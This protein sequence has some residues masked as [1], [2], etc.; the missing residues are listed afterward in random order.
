VVGML[1]WGEADFPWAGP[2][3]LV[4]GI[5]ALV[6]LNGLFVAVEFALVAVRK[7]RVEEMVRL[8]F[9]R[10]KTLEGAINHLDRSI[11]A[12][13][14]GTTLASI[15]LG[16][17]GEP[18]LARILQ[19]AFH[20]LPQSW[21]LAAA[22]TVATIIAF[23]LITF[24]HVVFGELVP[25]SLALQAPDRAALWLVFPLVIFTRL[26]RPLTAVMS[27]TANGILRL[28]GYQPVRGEE[29][30]HSVEE[31]A[32]LIE[33]TE[34]AGILDADQAEFVQNVF[35]MSNKKVREC[36]VPADK[37]ATLELNT[38]PDK[39]LEAARSGAHTRM[40]V[41]EGKLDNI[42]GIV[43]TKDLFYLFSLRGV[44][45]LHD[46]LYPALFLKPDNTVAEALR[47]FRKAH[48][49]MA[50][51]RDNQGK[52]LGL[53]TLEDVLEEIVGDIEDEHDRP[54]PKLSLRK[55]RILSA[56]AL[57]PALPRPGRK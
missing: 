27:S 49:P 22:H 50:L 4:L 35:R 34:E 37:M 9:K 48:R 12:T 13:Q 14:L 5:P 16:W 40:P 39:V 29:M 53:I 44:V 7:T 41:Y 30:V 19:P 8:G 31:L 55:S 17:L 21:G 23:I 24:M 6:V 2:L 51:V 43:N 25:K 45:V 57:P 52:I 1:I 11:A 46:A 54:T 56:P 20:F 47:M 3:L 38:P 18:A 28:L 33:D 15:G 10:A 32:L 26:T 36:L 42:V